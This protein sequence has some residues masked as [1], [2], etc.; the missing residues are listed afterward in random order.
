MSP[1]TIKKISPEFVD[2]RGGISNVLDAEIKHVAL[3]TSK[4][5]SIRGNHYHPDQVQYDYLLKGKYEYLVKDLKG[6]EGKVESTLVEAGTLVTTPPMTAH[7]MRFLE[8]SVFFTFTTGSRDTISYKD[9][10]KKFK[11][12]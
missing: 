5:G 4:A 7:V 6:E 8:D 12:I 11:L 1:V 10:T 9:H 3:I 2:D